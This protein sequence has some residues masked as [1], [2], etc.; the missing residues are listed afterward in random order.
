MDDAQQQP[1]TQDALSEI[2]LFITE[3]IDKRAE[4]NNEVI[5]ASTRERISRRIM[6]QL[7]IFIL[8]CT[9]EKLTIEEQ[10][11]FRTMIEEKKSDEELREYAAAHITDYDDF[12]VD[13]LL[14]FED[15]YLAGEFD[16]VDP[17]AAFITNLI[18]KKNLPNITPEIREEMSH[19]ITQRL[20]EFIMT[21]TLARFSE[22]QLAAFKQMLSEKKTKAELQQFAMHS[23]ADYASFLDETLMSFQEAYLS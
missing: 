17:R 16:S 9:L 10:E 7:D 5:N 18:E 13:V 8:D 4:K 20:D 15:A 22:E 11:F 6:A 12:I 21:R 19:D 2:D 1:H 23:I 3:L 14:D